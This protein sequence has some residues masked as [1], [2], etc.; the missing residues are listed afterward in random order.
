MFG[1][2]VERITSVADSTNEKNGDSNNSKMTFKFFKN[3]EIPEFFYN[4]DTDSYSKTP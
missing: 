1:Q 2:M 3:Q 4:I